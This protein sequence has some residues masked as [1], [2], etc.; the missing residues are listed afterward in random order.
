MHTIAHAATAA[1]PELDHRPLSRWGGRAAVAAPVAAVIAVVVGA[2]VYADDLSEAAA[3]GRFVVANAITLGVLLMLGLAL[4]G[5]YVHGERRLG[6][7]GHGGFLVA[8]AGVVL[9]AGGAWDSLF[10]V[11]WLADEAPAALDEPTGGSLLA[12]FVV[13]YLV[14]VIGW[15]LFAS[16][17]LRAGLAPRGASI[18]LI[19][20]AVLAIV[21][22]PT[23]LR[24]L[25]LAIGVALVARSA[26]R[27][28]GSA[29]P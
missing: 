15:V 7:L 16:A 27:G 19:A 12:G 5:L 4:L 25:P 11:P 21:P 6:A 18:A 14:L 28:S 20:G 23:A 13:S 10:A 24:L 9:A 29:R 26:L 1:A 17:S 3:T 22:A 8:L 2:P